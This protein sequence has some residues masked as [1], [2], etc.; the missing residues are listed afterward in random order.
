[1]TASVD[2]PLL[3]VV[4]TTYNR[5]HLLGRAIQSVLNQR[6]S[7]FEL[8]IVDDHATDNTAQI[9]AQWDDP[10]I[11]Y[12]RLAENRGASAAR[13]CGIRAAKAEFITFLDDDDEFLPDAL[14]ELYQALSSAPDTVGYI[15]GGIIRMIDTPQGEVMVHTYQPHIPPAPNREA[16]YLQFLH[17]APFGTGYGATFRRRVF[18]VVGLFDE[19]LWTAEDSDLFLRLVLHFDLMVIDK[20]VVRVH[21]HN[22]PQ[23]TDPSLKRATALERIS[24]KHLDTLRRHPRLYSYQSYT[25]ALAYYRCNAKTEAR[26]AFWRAARLYPFHCGKV[27][28]AFLCYELFQVSPGQI[29]Q[30]MWPRRITA[31]FLL[32]KYR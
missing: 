15:I 24:Q 29:R 18:D 27:W 11:R 30:R 25:L 26:R 19:Q 4:I 2:K 8:L 17:K 1:M 10:R 13:N 31:Q 12:L 5:A 21:R 16:A 7:A 23:L 9:V 28:L 20:L 32:D 14:L 22:A 3:S 6:F